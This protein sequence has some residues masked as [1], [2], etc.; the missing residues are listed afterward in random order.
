MM[1]VLLVSLPS[2]KQKERYPRKKRHT[3]IKEPLLVHF[4]ALEQA[5]VVPCGEVTV[6]FVSELGDF[7]K[8]MLVP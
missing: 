8:K 7:H 5:A 4:G 6:G 2:H 1:V 3:Q